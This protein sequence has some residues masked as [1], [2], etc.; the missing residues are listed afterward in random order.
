MDHIAFFWTRSYTKTLVF[1]P[2]TETIHTSSFFLSFFLPLWVW[3]LGELLC[4]CL[5]D[6]STTR[7]GARAQ[8]GMDLGVANGNVTTHTLTKGGG[9]GGG[10][11][12]EEWTF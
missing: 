7:N 8:S 10:A 5:L 2:S 12:A 6:K 4:L 11:R 1:H 9:G 3:I